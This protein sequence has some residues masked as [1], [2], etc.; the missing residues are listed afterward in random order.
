MKNTPTCRNKYNFEYYFLEIC[1]VNRAEILSEFYE[2]IKELFVKILGHFTEKC[3]HAYTILS[4]KI[5][6]TQTSSV[7]PN[8]PIFENYN[9]WKF[10]I[11]YFSKNSFQFFDELLL[12][13]VL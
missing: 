3:L 5:T 11:F 6:L 12:M 1:T 7:W 8:P 4:D 13:K 9:W 10:S 2:C